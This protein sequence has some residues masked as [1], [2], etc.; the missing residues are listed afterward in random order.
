MLQ[1][2]RKTASLT[3]DPL[4]KLVFSRRVLDEF[5]VFQL[6]F[7]WFSGLWTFT[8]LLR[9]NWIL[10]S[11]YGRWD[12]RVFVGNWI[13]FGFRWTWTW[14]VFIKTFRFWVLDLDGFFQRIKEEV[15]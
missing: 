1:S 9:C 5:L 14:M 11:F 2:K 3:R 6:D 4:L 10:N 8:V 12:F 7:N 13:K 15:D